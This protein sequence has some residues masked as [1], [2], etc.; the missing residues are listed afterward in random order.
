MKKSTKVLTVAGVGVGVGVATAAFL[1]T[2]KGQEV[3]EVVKEKLT[4]ALNELEA[5]R[6]G[7]EE[8]AE[9]QPKTTKLFLLESVKE[10]D[11]ATLIEELEEMEVKVSTIEEETEEQE[12]EK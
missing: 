5:L 11:K 7:E 8:N 4:M 9:V 2:E 10:K 6:K 1:K 3:K 12:E